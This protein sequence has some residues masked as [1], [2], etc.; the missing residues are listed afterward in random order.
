MPITQDNYLNLTLNRKFQKHKNK[1]AIYFLIPIL[2]LFYASLFFVF[3]EAS[4]LPANY[5]K[6]NEIRFSFNKYLNKP[7]IQIAYEIMPGD[8][9]FSIA[10]KHYEST[11]SIANLQLDNNIKNPSLDLKVGTTINISNPKVIDIYKVKSGDTIF[12]ISQS[13]FNR[14]WYTNYVQSF[15]EI[16]DTSKDLKVGMKIS[17][18][19][20][21][22]TIIHTVQPGETLYGIVL[23]Y[24]Q[25]SAFQELI[26]ECNEI[27]NP[28][29]LKAGLAI[30]IPN[31]FYIDKS[32][33]KATISE[34]KV[35]YSIEINKTKNNL[36]IF[37]NKRLVRTFPVATGKNINLTPIGTF[38]IVNKIKD[39]WYSPKSIPGG[40]PKNPLG[41]RWLG[42]N[43]PNTKGTKYGIHGTNN[44]TSIGKYASLGC[45][46]MN[47]KDVQWLYDY[48]PTGTIVIIKN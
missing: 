36:S 12:S 41:T 32:I 22:S 30:K 17:I 23:K 42:L 48:I 16:N 21:K 4:T 2:I 39:P 46:R 47:N 6:N 45:I 9:I 19:L 24:F 15:N 38:K 27:A 5:L 40:T 20:T 29:H 28:T 7:N 37:K 14:G 26:I 10:R 35:S 25:T 43:V 34:Q 8:T 18:P 44:P 1:R 11:E 33:L 31:P 13:Y 3:T